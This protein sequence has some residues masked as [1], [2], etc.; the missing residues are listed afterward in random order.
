MLQ[1]VFLPMVYIHGT[2]YIQTVLVY[3]TLSLKNETYS[4]LR[5]TPAIVTVVFAL[6]K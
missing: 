5:K 3:G 2:W 4:V 1:V 6:Q